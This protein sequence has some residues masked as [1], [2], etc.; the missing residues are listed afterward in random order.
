MLRSM[1]RPSLCLSALA[2]RHLCS[3]PIA[4]G[5]LQEEEGAK[6]ERP[7]ESRLEHRF[8][9]ND[10]HSFAGQLRIGESPLA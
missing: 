4:R 1:L 6:A 3:A 8:L 2:L 9:E 7:S 10:F 5:S